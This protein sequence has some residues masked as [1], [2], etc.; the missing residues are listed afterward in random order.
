[1]SDDWG[2]IA[3]QEN[4]IEG[5]QEFKDEG[6]DSSSSS[7]CECTMQFVCLLCLSFACLGS[8]RQA[9]ALNGVGFPFLTIFCNCNINRVLS[10]IIKSVVRPILVR[11]C[12]LW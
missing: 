8:W 4:A 12:I 9:I 5:V 10:S 2:C 3:R 6:I 7:C 11:L 1:M